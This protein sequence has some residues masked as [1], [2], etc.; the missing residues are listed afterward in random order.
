MHRNSQWLL[1][2]IDVLC[3]CA[4]AACL[5]AFVWLTLIRD[6]QTG[7][8]IRVLTQRIHR[9]QTDSRALRAEGQRQREILE[10]Y[11][12]DLAKTGQLPTETPIEEYFQ[13]LSM[14]ASNHGL[15]V[16][17]HQPETS[18]EYPGLREQRYACELTGPFPQL[19]GFLKSIEETDFWADVSHL[20]LEGGKT[21]LSGPSSERTALLT[22][23]L[24]SAMPVDTASNEEGA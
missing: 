11:R 7:V 23:S 1:R 3:G 24:F 9:I 5:L 18:R 19:V 21:R 15:R 16:V 6:D 4:V 2:V 13:A 20:K 17:K 22:I 12:D 14:L 10:T 8:D